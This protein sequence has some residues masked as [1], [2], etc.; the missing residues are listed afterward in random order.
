M[1]NVYDGTGADKDRNDWL[2]P[3]DYML[4]IKEESVDRFFRKK[5]LPADTVAILSSLTTGTDSLGN[6]IYYYT[7]DLNTL[8][9]NQIR[10]EMNPD[11]MNMMLVHVTVENKTNA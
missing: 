11:T 6:T 7:Y 10:Q 8:L 3:A 4:L 1:L 2:Q 5:E 9:T